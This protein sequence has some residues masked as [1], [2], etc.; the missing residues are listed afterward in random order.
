MPLDQQLYPGIGGR[1]CGAFLSPIFRDPHPTCTRCRGR[2]CFS[3]MT[4]DICKDWSV[5]QWEAFLEKNSY[6][7]CRKSRPSGSSLPSAPL[8]SPPIAFAS[9]EAG[10]PSTSLLLPPVLQKGMGLR[11]GR[12]DVSRVGAR[13][14]SPPPSSSRAGGNDRLWSRRESSRLSG[15]LRSHSGRSRSSGYLTQSQDRSRSRERSWRPKQ[16]RRDRVEAHD[17][18]QDRGNSGSHAG[19]ASVVAGSSRPGL[20][21]SLCDLARLFLSLS[22]SHDQWD[23]V[24]GSLSAEA[25]SEAGSLPGSVAPGRVSAPSACSSACVPAPGVV[26][27]LCWCLSGRSV[28]PAWAFLGFPL[29][30]EALQALV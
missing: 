19:S 25:V 26:F 21:P 27:P 10:R 14:A 7:G 12:G 15:R 24:A 5:A 16:G 8:P 23:E 29:L 11:R 4:S 6:I 28:R 3:D 17:V 9:S 2:K 20:E 18:S 13:G 30:G 22:G 1:K